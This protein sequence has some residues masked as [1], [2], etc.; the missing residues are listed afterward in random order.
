MVGVPR[1]KGCHLCVKRR[2]K[3]DEAKPQ[4][5]ACVRYGVACPGYD[6]T[7]KFVNEKHQVRPRVKAKPRKPSSPP[8]SGPGAASAAPGT[9]DEFLTTRSRND[10]LSTTIVLSPT[11]LSPTIDRAQFICTMLDTLYTTA[12]RKEIS[13]LNPWFDGIQDQFGAKAT[14]D[15]AATSLILHML[16]KAT[17]DTRLVG[18]SRSLYGQSLMALQSA[19]N[20]RT[21]W[22]ASETLSASTVLCLFELF[23]GTKSAVS[24]MEHA[25]GVTW[26]IQQRGP[27][28]FKD[29]WD[30][31][32]FKNFR[33]LVIMNSIFSGEDCFL[34]QDKWQDVMTDGSADSGRGML[35]DA[36]TARRSKVAD[37]Y[38]AL[39]A[40]IPSVLR[41]AYPLREARKKGLAVDNTTVE[42]L[43]RYATGLCRDYLAFE[44]DMRQIVADP[45]DVPSQDPRSPFATVFWYE[46]PWVGALHIGYWASMLIVQ[47]CLLHCNMASLDGIRFTDSIPDMA[48]KI[49]RSF[50]NVGGGIMGGYRVGYAMRVVYEFVDLPTQL[51]ITS[52]LHDYEG[53]YAGLQVSVFPAPEHVEGNEL[54]PK[55]LSQMRPEL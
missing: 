5:H 55:W 13:F 15:S 37:Q 14:L 42:R 6:R 12:S 21:E 40:K 51:W 17:G 34:V 16:G 10:S 8:S 50:E 4:C 43:S 3:C 18:E 36:L 11:A 30:R 41:R 9:E 39:L 27:E 54:L 19:L 1:S 2:V 44:K 52:L 38:F 35:I 22:K 45:I 7:V 46:N 33:A 29:G 32:T 48:S 20:H 28:C 24:W 47:E 23:A 53:T 25:K 26:L 31:V 49:L